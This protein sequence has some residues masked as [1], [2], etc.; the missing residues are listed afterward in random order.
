MVFFY[1]F[2]LREDRA[3][4]AA[5]GFEVLIHWGAFKSHEHELFELQE[6]DREE[7][8]LEGRVG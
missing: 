8:E 4:G 5:R 3:L 1:S 2:F 6:E 7:A